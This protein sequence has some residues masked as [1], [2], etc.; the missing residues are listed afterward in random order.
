DC[1]ILAR[2]NNPTGNLISKEKILRLAEVSSVVVDESFID[3]LDAES[4]RKFVSEKISVVQSLTKIFAIP[5]LRLGF[6]VVEENLARRLNLSKDVW[7]VNFLAQKAGAAAL[8]DEDF[9][10]RTRAW[11]E[12]ERKFFVD[13]LTNLRGVKVFPPTANFVL[14]R[15]E[16]AEKILAE[17]R[18]EKILLRSCANFA[19]LDKNYLRSAIRSRE[20]NLRLFNVLEKIL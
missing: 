2:P 17:L 6:A 3:F 14:F 11:L 19:G 20:E 12:V 7:N 1:V 9:L 8:S 16:H 18:R 5:G 10:R 4:I 15:H 13:R